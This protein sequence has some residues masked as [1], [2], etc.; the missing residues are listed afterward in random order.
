MN[1]VRENVLTFLMRLRTHYW[2]FFFASLGLETRIPDRI[3]VTYPF[4]IQIGGNCRINYGVILN[5]RGG[6]TIGDN[7]TISN[8]AIINTVSLTNARTHDH[9]LAPVEIEHD[10]W[11]C[12]GA[13]INPGVRVG[14]HAI[15]ASGAVVTRDVAPHTV[16]G[17][18]PARIINSTITV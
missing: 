10:A 1:F 9:K 7:V 4:R 13:I 2:R 6:L 8:R 14:A 15:V 3:H 11:I 18:V 5:G 12:S 16:V 17:G